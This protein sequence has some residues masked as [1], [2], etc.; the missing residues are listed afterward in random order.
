VVEVL[1]VPAEPADEAL[2]VLYVA[3]LLL[4]VKLEDGLLGLAGVDVHDH[5]LL[6]GDVAL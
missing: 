3:D 5:L 1:V 4:V 2:V 6:F